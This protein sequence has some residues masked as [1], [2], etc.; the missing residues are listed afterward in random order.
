MQ[1]RTLTGTIAYWTMFFLTRIIMFLLAW[2]IV[3]IVRAFRFI[4][5]IPVKEKAPIGFHVVR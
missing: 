4:F 5:R 2:S 3:L 1:N